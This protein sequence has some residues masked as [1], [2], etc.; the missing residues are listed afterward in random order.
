ME[1]HA[2]KV[3]SY[4]VVN[5]LSA[6]CTHIYVLGTVYFL[7]LQQ[8]KA[9]SMCLKGLIKIQ[10]WAWLTQDK[11]HLNCLIRGYGPKRCNIL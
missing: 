11:G 2:I 4:K 5:L 3:K 6:Y 10:E 7:Y 1:N 8:L 9:F